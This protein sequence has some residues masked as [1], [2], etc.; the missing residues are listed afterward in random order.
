MLRPGGYATITD[1]AGRIIRE[2]DTFTCAHGN[3]IVRVPAGVD[4]MTVGQYCRCCMKHICEK[5]AAEMNRT[6]KC[7]PFEKL[8]ERWESRDALLKSILEEAD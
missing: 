7:V 2:N 1:D 6:L 8:L 5:C 4:P 3:E